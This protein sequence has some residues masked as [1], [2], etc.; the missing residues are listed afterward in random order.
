MTIPLDRRVHKG[1]FWGGGWV[2]F[3]RLIRFWK[4]IF[5]KFRGFDPFPT[6]IHES[7][8]GWAA[9]FRRRGNI[10]RETGTPFVIRTKF[11]EATFTTENRR[12][13][14]GSHR[15]HYLTTYLKSF[16]PSVD[17]WIS[18]ATSGPRGLKMSFVN[19]RFFESHSLF[20]YFLHSY[21]RFT[22]YLY[23]ESEMSFIGSI[24]N[25]IHAIK[26]FR[27]LKIKTFFFF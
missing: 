7:A 19:F 18:H 4:L 16:E 3:T 12:K 21:F 9:A 1:T 26:W 17:F 20:I 25:E 13:P 23:F 27:V 15:C 2:Y 11:F 10:E 8:S 14:Y 22:R 5:R 24:M 6:P